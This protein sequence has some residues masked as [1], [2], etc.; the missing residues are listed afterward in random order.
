MHRADPGAGQHGIGRFGDH[1]HIDGD[2]VAFPDAPGFQHIGEFAHFLVKLLVGDVLAVGGIVA[3]PD[4]GGLV[5]ARRQVPVDAIGRDIQR[6]ILEPFDGEVGRVER[7]ILD[8]GERFDPVQPRRLLAPIAVGV[9][10]RRRIGG[11]IL[12]LGHEGT[13]FPFLRHRDQA[14]GHFGS[15]LSFFWPRVRQMVL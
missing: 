7:D 1:R 3:F 13:F 14:L 11:L 4:D 10:H 5:A 8:L 2:A 12:R 15:L 9:F 6:S